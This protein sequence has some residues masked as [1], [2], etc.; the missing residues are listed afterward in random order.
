MPRCFLVIWF[1]VIKTQWDNV[2]KFKDYRCVAW[3]VRSKSDLANLINHLSSALN[4]S[5]RRLYDVPVLTCHRTTAQ[6]GS[7][8]AIHS[9][10][11]VNTT[12]PWLHISRPPSWWRGK[13]ALASHTT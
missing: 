4:S 5:P 3:Q 13:P 7:P 10:Q 6:R 2:V 1:S 9:Q 8:M 12:K 11:R